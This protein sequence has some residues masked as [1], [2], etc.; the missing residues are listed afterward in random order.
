MAGVRTAVPLSSLKDREVSRYLE[1]NLGRIVEVFAPRHVILFGSRADGEARWD[2]D[3]DL[4]VV[5]EV[6]GGFPFW[7]GG[8][9]STRWFRG[10]C[11][12]MCGV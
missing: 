9:G 11:G 4:I 5:S 1:A 8:D 3:I 12:W 2:S 7:S 10:H 6:F